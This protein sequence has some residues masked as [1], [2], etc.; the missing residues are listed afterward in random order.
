MA[1][2]AISP[3]PEWWEIEKVA[4]G[5]E[6]GEAIQGCTAEQVE[7]VELWVASH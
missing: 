2:M 6:A 3:A 4:V 1:K 7:A 5:E